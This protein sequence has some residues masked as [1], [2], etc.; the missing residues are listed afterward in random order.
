MSRIVT[1]TNTSDTLHKQAQDADSAKKTGV[2]GE[3]AFLNFKA[4]EEDLVTAAD[5]LITQ[6]RTLHDE[7]LL[8]QRIQEAYWLGVQVDRAELEKRNKWTAPIVL[9]KI[10]QTLETI[11][12]NV[13]ARTPSPA[14]SAPT[15]KD[16]KDEVEMRAYAMQVE[17]MILGVVQDNKPRL[18]FEQFVR[19]NQLYFLG[20][21]KFGYDEDTK[22]I[23]IKAIRPQRIF[24]PPYPDPDYVGEYHEESGQWVLDTFGT[25]VAKKKKIKEAIEEGMSNKEKNGGATAESTKVAFYEI[26]TA[27]VKVWIMEKTLLGKEKNPY[28]DWKAEKNNHWKERKMDYIFS[29]FQTLDLSQY[30][31]TTAVEQIL[32]LQD[33]VNKRKRQISD[34]ADGAQGTTIGLGDMGV[35]QKDLTV[36]QKKRKEPGGVAFI[37]KGMHNSIFQIEGQQL[38]PYVFD[39]MIH[40]TKEIDNIV[41]TH[42]V[43]RGEKTPGEETLGGKQLLKSGDETRL[44]PY[45]DT[46]ERAAET[47]YNGIAQIIK[48]KFKEA[49]ALSYL[50]EDGS[51][52]YVEIKSDFVKRGTR[53]HVRPGS[54]LIK[55]KSALAQEAIILWQQKALDPITLFERLGDPNPYRTAERLFL[56]QNAPERLFKAVASELSDAKAQVDEGQAMSAVIQAGIENQLISQGTQPPPF[57]GTNP[58]HMAIHQELLEQINQLAAQGQQPDDKVVRALQGHMQSE[59]PILQAWIAEKEAEEKSGKKDL[60]SPVAKSIIQNEDAATKG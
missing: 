47:L 30:S 16:L 45:A 5:S 48:V 7:M 39:D 33:A 31:A 29:D 18:L 17:N 37:E 41:G 59:L 13:V 27:D 3:R 40:T 34:N 23:W 46:L 4:K 43:T 51:T 24:I 60:T 20:V 36:L 9:N 50:S 58:Q 12:P 32:S 53:I 1:R 22:Q 42:A 19:F 10:Y 35:T 2:I 56:Y 26:T 38:E 14:V 25:S 57:P 15:T 11:I 54:T 21:L 28:W 44:Q 6:A 8:K 52:S 55:D 49:Q